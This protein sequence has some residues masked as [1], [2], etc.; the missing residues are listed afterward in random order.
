[1]WQQP[2][3]VAGSTAA[4]CMPW[5]FCCHPTGTRAPGARCTLTAPI[6]PEVGDVGLVLGAVFG[7]LA[8]QPEHLPQCGS[9]LLAADS[10]RRGD[11]ELHT[12]RHSH[13]FPRCNNLG[14][15]RTAGSQLVLAMEQLGVALLCRGSKASTADT[16]SVHRVPQCQPACPH[17]AGRRPACK[18]QARDSASGVQAG[19]PG[20]SVQAGRR[21]CRQRAG[22]RP[23]SNV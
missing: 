17:C 21:P 12:G 16:R 20:S 1:M 18:V 10:Q 8:A 22:K 4:T 6:S 5:P 14:H 23:A 11:L 19:G 3:K 9:V 2:I 15:A 7:G 13:F